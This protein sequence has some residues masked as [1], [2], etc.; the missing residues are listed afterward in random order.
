MAARVPAGATNA[1]MPVGMFSCTWPEVI[2]SCGHPIVCIPQHLCVAVLVCCGW[3][4]RTFTMSCRR[5]QWELLFLPRNMEVL[6]LPWGCV[7]SSG[8]LDGEWDGKLCS[9]PAQFNRVF[10]GLGV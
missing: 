5:A 7:A 9:L 8:I 3:S 10:A 2:Q 1:L 6:P 4:K